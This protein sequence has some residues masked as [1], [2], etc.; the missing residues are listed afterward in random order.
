MSAEAQL[1]AGRPVRFPRQAPD[2]ERPR[3]RKV[4]VTDFFLFQGL[5]SE[6]LE[7]GAEKTAVEAA[8]STVD[9][10]DIRGSS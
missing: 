6:W 5:L 4:D 8:S 9:Q 3:K 2:M 7:D 10:S 1:G